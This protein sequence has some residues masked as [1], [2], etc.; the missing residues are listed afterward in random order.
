MFDPKVIEG[1]VLEKLSEFK[2]P[3]IAVAVVDDRKVVYSRAFGFR[4][5]ENL[6]P[7]TPTTMYGIGSVTKSFTA[8]SIMQLAEKGKLD[9][10][11]PITKYVDIRF[12][13][14]LGDIEIHHLLTHS[15]GIPALAY[16]EAFIDSSVGAGEAWLPITKDED[17]LVF[18]DK[19]VE[20]WISARP[21]ERFFYLNEGYVILGRIVSRVS[22]KEYERY[23]KEEILKPL[24]MKK[25]CF[26][27]EEV[28]ELG[29]WAQPY[30]IDKD[31]KIIRSRFPFG[32]TADG[33]LISTVLD[34][35]NYI[36]MYLNGGEFDGKKVISSDSVAKMTM[37]YIKMPYEGKP[38]YYYGYGWIIKDFLG[39]KLIS[40][41]G[42]VL[43][44][45]AYV[46]FIPEKNIGVAVLANSS[47]YPLSQIGEYILAHLLGHDPEKL[48]FVRRERILKSLEG[49]YYTFKRTMRIDVKR[50]GEFLLAT[51]KSRYWEIT[52]VLV[53]EHLD[54]KK[55]VFF[56]Y[57][58]GRKIT[59]E[60]I[61]ED[62]KVDMYFE[63]YRLRK[64]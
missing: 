64:T 24:K 5:V 55:S 22:G 53:P 3:S 39:H 52:T 63:R 54:E 50:H 17:I 11:D 20:D 2:L 13:P 59:I 27:K 47:G 40:H 60:F 43:V 36:I 29:E 12:E 25:S 38:E 28:E 9:L 31:G 4:D 56:T 33:G 44:Y 18:M 35:S 41:S 19:E 34:L 30:I 15:S 21:G 57:S 45:T 42:S 8:L 32:I 1:F 16:A 7:A 6:L 51:E 37:G 58:R 26:S 10:H 46:G 23:V 62:G 61:V 14:K 49:T 48:D